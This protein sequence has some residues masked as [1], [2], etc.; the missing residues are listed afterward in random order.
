VRE[1][2]SAYTQ[3]HYR[4]NYP[5]GV[6]FHYWNQCRN[7]L[8]EAL[9][10]RHASSQKVID[11]GCGRGIVVD[12][13]RRRGVDAW[14][15]ELATPE[16]ITGA[17]APFLEMGRDALEAASRSG[18]RCGLVLDVLEHLPEPR[19]FLTAVASGM[20]EL[21]RL[22]ITVPARSEIWSEWDTA[23]GHFRR[24]DRS[25]LERLVEGADLR[26]IES[27]Y[28]FHSL[29]VAARALSSLP[30]RRST[31][32]RPPITPLGRWIH[33]SVGAA[34]SL[35]RRLLPGWIPGSS[36]YAV[37]AVRH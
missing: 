18:A 21:E 27:G 15:C 19:S 3:Q 33:R 24:Y 16:P 11:I 12:H 28:F 17:V 5:D 7:R 30:G 14:G 8:I 37:A 20:P 25:D 34:L 2:P 26:L 29:Y 10:R 23:Y 1:H 31:E 36:L 35:E 32:M 9:V 6:Q 13:L 4:A 22:I